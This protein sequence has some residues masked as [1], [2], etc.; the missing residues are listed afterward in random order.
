MRG[1]TVSNTNKLI[2]ET[3]KV[4]ESNRGRRRHG[5]LKGWED[6]L[7]ALA[8][9]ARDER[10]DPKTSVTIDLAPF[11]EMPRYKREGYLWDA[12]LTALYEVNPGMVLELDTE[13][14]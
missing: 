6:Y 8:K 9:A 4:M 14:E 2:E 10:P 1:K 13:D 3:I 12:A 11:L 7:D 5:V